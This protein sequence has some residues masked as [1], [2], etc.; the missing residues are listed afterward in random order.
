MKKILFAC[1]AFSLV[2]FACSK[3]DSAGASDEGSIELRLTDGPGMFEA[4]NID[5]IGAEIKTSKDTAKN[6][7]WLPLTVRTGVF[8]ILAL[9]NGVDTLLGSTKLPLADIKEIRLMLGANNSVKV[10]GVT[11]PLTIP[12]GGES[13]LKLKFEH[14]LLA[15]VTY[16][17]KL[18]FDAAKSIKEE[19]KGEYKLRPRLRLITVANDGAVRGEIAPA[20]CKSVVYAVN[21]TDTITSAF[22]SSLGRFVLQGLDAGTYKIVVDAETCADKVIDGVKVEVGKSTNLEKIT[23]Q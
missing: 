12:S 1:V 11:Y 18:D 14:K 6:G 10:G 15:G 22:P 21:G 7:G 19:K 3:D 8:N 9:S 13:G 17:V 5:I 16:K 23:L 4:V 2:I 20:T